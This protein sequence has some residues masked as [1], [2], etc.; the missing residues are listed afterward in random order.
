V[1]RINFSNVIFLTSRCR[2]TYNCRKALQ[3]GT[4]GWL[5]AT[6]AMPTVLIY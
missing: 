6:R 3:R 4:V 5:I 2:Q 1:E